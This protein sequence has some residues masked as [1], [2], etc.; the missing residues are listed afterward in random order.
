MVGQ[1]L[2]NFWIGVMLVLFFSIRHPV[3]PAIGNATA[4]AY[5][6]PVLTLS[7]VLIATL[8]RT[9]RQSMLETLHEP[10]IRTARAKGISRTRILFVHALKNA[11]IPLVTVLGLQVGFVLGGAFVVEL[12]FNW[13]GVGLLALQ[14]ID[15]RDFPVVQGVVIA[16]AVVFVLANLAVDVA[17]AYLNPRVRLGVGQ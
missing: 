13:P 3:F 16:V 2:P 7:A 4:S 5:V 14:A 8:L 15:T 10:Y 12:V 11:A 17:Y 1:S 9:A 6:L